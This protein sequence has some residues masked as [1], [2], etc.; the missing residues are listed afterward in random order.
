M[1]RIKR[2][3]YIFIACILVI[4]VAGFIYLAYEQIES[5]KV[6]QRSAD[7]F[8]E[9]KSM[10]EDFVDLCLDNKISFIDKVDREDRDELKYNISKY[11]IYAYQELSAQT[12]QKFEEIL[13]VFIENNISDIFVWTYQEGELA[14]RMKYSLS[15][16]FSWGS[17]WADL[18][19]TDEYVSNVEELLEYEFEEQAQHLDQEHWVLLYDINDKRVVT[20]K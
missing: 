3:L 5:R 10:L 13:S 19:Y 16:H 9:H 17:G 4:I 8:Y 1:K 18:L 6:P 14:E 20:K 15:I 2:E 7:F 11:Y 12:Q